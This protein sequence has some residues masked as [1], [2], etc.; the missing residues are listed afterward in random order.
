MKYT[1]IPYTNKQHIELLKQRGLIISDVER[2]EKYLETIGYYRLSGY[3]FHLQNKGNNDNF[4]TGTTFEQI[5]E[6]YKFDKALRSII[7]EYIER[8]EVCLRAKISNKYSLKHGFYWY[9]DNN[10]FA[11]SIIYETIK[12]EISSS[13]EDPQERF[14][15]SFKFKYHEET[16]PPSNMALEILTFGK[17]SRLFKA[18]DFNEIKEEISNDFQLLPNFLAGYFVYINNVRN[19]CAHHSR[20]WN[21]KVTADRP[22]IPT[23]KKYKFNGSVPE[24]FNTSVYGIISIIHRL[25]KPFNPNNSFTS[26]IT[27]LISDYE[28]N[29]SLMGFPNDWE[30]EATWLKD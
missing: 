23:R 17:L 1:K 10:L 12:K 14:L 5:I 9:L 26:R 4:I 2:A 15:K 24:D 30:K 29:T 20:L 6:L 8:I 25:L 7:L 19:I 28:I 16:F 22:S 21:K 13:F 3:M 27:N 18:L 11:D